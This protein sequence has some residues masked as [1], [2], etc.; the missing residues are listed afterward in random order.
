MNETIQPRRTIALPWLHVGAIPGCWW[1]YIGASFIAAIALV[2]NGQFIWA[3]PD[4]TTMPDHGSILAGYNQVHS[5]SDT[6]KWWHGAWIH[7]QF[8][9][10]RP[11]SSYLYWFQCYL[12]TN[13]GWVWASWVAFA[14]FVA[15][16]LLL[17]AVAWKITQN[18]WLS[19]AA[20]IGFAGV[21]YLLPG[22]NTSMPLM[23]WYPVAD[24]LASLFFALGAV[25]AWLQWKESGNRW[26]LVATYGLFVCS[27]LSKEWGYILPL[28]LAALIIPTGNVP[29]RRLLL[30]GASMLCVSVLLFA[31]RT[32]TI[33]NGHRPANSRALAA[34]MSVRLWIPPTPFDVFVM[35][36]PRAV[37]AIAGYCIAIG[38]VWAA[39]RYRD[40]L[41]AI[42]QDSG[43]A[44]VLWRCVA[45]W[46][47][48]QLALVP[49]LGFAI[50]AHYGLWSM[51]FR[52]LFWASCAQAAY[53]F[54]M[55]LVK[56]IQKKY[57]RVRF[58]RPS[59]IRC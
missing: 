19:L 14:L 17:S 47:C 13:Y 22:L 25:L 7:G 10:L 18:Y 34:E 50:E 27:A 24:N 11:L 21:K 58:P 6:L 1:P 8:P 55:L 37:R 9:S 46:A 39:W 16:C 40:A 45:L 12:G 49:C 36:G 51:A 30:H 29:A 48:V 52:V 54:L 31:L 23:S 33:T 15:C 5:F 43:I 41:K 2:V 3:R 38:L 26:V 20:G 44:P 57:H 4:M 28:I 53:P 42:V 59:Y 35:D 56:A 32:A